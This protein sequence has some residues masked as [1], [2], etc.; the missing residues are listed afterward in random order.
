MK[1]YV[2]VRVT[3]TD[4]ERYKTYAALVPAII[5][6]YGGTYLVRGGKSVTL[7][8]PAETGRVVVMEFPRWRRRRNS[9][10]RRSTSKPRSFAQARPRARCWRSR[11]CRT[12][13]RTRESLRRDNC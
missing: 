13:Q 7:E 9:I 2:I 10:T 12:V 3:V 1:A 8:G 5:A 4:P 11:A 6:Q